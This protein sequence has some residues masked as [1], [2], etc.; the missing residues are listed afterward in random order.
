MNDEPKTTPSV[1]EDVEM[2]LR[3]RI[4]V[5]EEG[6]NQL[7][8]SVKFLLLATFVLAAAAALTLMLLRKEKAR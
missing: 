8:S 4:T 1:D 7:V 6:H 2:Q 3:S 5:L